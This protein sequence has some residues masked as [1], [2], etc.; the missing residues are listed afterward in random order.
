MFSVRPGPTFEDALK[1]YKE[2]IQRSQ[3][4]IERL[5]DLFLRLNTTHQAELASTVHFATQFYQK[6]HKK[7]PT[8]TEV[9]N[10]VME[11]KQRRKPSFEKTEVAKTIRNLASLGLISVRPSKDLPVAE[12]VFV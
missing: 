12:E 11:W 1:L 4:I 10:A 3:H 9:L 5:I 2:E 6:E 8:E 7:T